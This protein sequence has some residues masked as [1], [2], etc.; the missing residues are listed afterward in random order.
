[1]PLPGRYKPD[2]GL[3]LPKAGVFA[4][5]HGA[6]A[7]H[8]IA[9]K[10]LGRTTEETFDGKGYCFLETGARRAVKANGA[11]FA[12]PHP[13]MEKRAPDEAQLREKFEWVERLLQ[14]L[15]G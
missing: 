1:M 14:P 7:A 10:V 11:F 13:L 6:T 5:A 4:A 2:V 12:L 8:H 9:A 3:A 15:R